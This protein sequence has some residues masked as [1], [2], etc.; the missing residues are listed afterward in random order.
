MCL[1]VGFPMHASTCAVLRK[2]STMLAECHIVSQ[3]DTSIDGS[4]Q[5]SEGSGH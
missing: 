1:T 5:V 2:S 4:H 3:T